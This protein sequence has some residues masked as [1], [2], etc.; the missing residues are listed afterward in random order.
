MQGL[1]ILTSL[2]MGLLNGLGLTSMFQA[3]IGGA[4][5]IILVAMAVGLILK[6]R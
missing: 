1:A 4:L 2:G 3:F 5:F 6:A